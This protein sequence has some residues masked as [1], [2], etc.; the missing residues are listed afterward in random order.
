MRWRLAM[1]RSSAP[2]AC[3][4]L[5]ANLGP[6]LNRSNRLRCTAKV[7]DYYT[8]PSGEKNK[9]KPLAWAVWDSIDKRYVGDVHY[10]SEKTATIAAQVQSGSRL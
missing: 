5:D 2:R 6:A 9:K 10:K 4:S 1:P 8:Y 7:V 3:D